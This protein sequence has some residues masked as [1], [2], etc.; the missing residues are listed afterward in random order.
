MSS[1]AASLPGQR[2]AMFTTLVAPFLPFSIAL[3]DVGLAVV[4]RWIRGRKIYLPDTDH[5]HHR[6]AA[7]F[8]SPV[9]VNLVV[10]A[11]S[12][13]LAAMAV[14]AVAYPDVASTPVVLITVAILLT[15]LTVIL[16][17][18]YRVDPFR[19][20]PV[21]LTERRHYRFLDLY[22]DYMISRLGRTRSVRRVRVVAGNGS[23]RSRI[24]RGVA[25]P[26]GHH[27]CQVEER[28]PG[29]YWF[30]PFNAG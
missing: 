29:S 7:E 12:A 25:L 26:E 9:R 6:L 20:L 8:K 27:D 24:R 16:L 30:T 11:F 18:T 13:G 2:S 17:R 10:Y 14:L 5:L 3:L 23:P 21:V 28:E 19:H 15:G 22:S 1:A 4:R